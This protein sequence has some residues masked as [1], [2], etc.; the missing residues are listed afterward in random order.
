MSQGIAVATS[1]SPRCPTQP[2]SRPKEA[3]GAW[4]GVHPSTIARKYEIPRFLSREIDQKIFEKWLRRKAQAHV[5][6]DRDRGYQ[7]A[8]GEVYRGLIYD[9]VKSS[10]GY[11]AYTG[12]RLAWA[13]VSKFRNEE[14][15]TRGHG[16][17]REFALVPTVDHYNPGVWPPEFRI[18]SMRTNDAK[19]SMTEEEFLSLC[20]RVIAHAKKRKGRNRTKST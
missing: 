2:A 8:I 20:R 10:R 3:R 15:K 12:E 18:C 6:R 14:A 11:D 1:A 16:Y 5:V 4:A 19:S 13:Q 7:A 9:A 17:R